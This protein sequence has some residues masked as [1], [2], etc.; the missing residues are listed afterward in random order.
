[1]DHPRQPHL[2]GLP[3]PS[4]APSLAAIAAGFDPARLTQGR[5]LA[6][7]TKRAVADHLRVSPVAVSQW[8]AGTHVPRPDHIGSLADVLGVPP[9]FLAIG[10]P[11]ARLESSAAHFRSPRK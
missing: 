8:E 2:L 3:T 11:Y 1:M 10:R 4:D 7:L 5:C 6:G 9:A